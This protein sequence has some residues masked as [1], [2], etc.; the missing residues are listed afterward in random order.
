MVK[1]LSGLVA[2]IVIAVGGFFGFQFYTQHRI[3]SEV[4][5]ALEQVRA[6]G[7]KA[8][9]G[10]V[11]YDLLNR[12]VTIAEIAAQSAAQ[13]PVS[14]KIGN[15]TAS[16]VSQPDAAR[17]S[18]ETI[19]IADLDIG[20]AIGPQP[21]SNLS[22][23]LPRIT[24]K[25][26]SGPASLQRPPASSAL[27]DIYRSVLEQFAGVAA[28]SI[29]APSLTGTIN[30]GV[31]TPGGGEVAYTGLAMQDIKDGKVASAK[32]DGAVF[33]VNA[34]GAGGKPDKLT[35][36]LA[37]IAGYDIDSRAVAAMFD[38]Q[39]A[40]DD[41]YY[42]AYRQITTGPYVV[43]SGQGLNMRIDGIT[44][45]DL[46][47]RPSRMQ[48]PDLLAMIPAPGAAPPTPAQARAM[49]EKVAKLYEG[50]RIG[51]AEMR[52]FS[53]ETP[54][55]PVKLSAMRLDLDN[56]KVNEFAIEGVDGRAP[57]GPVKLG[58]FALKSLDV[59]NL[60]R[61]SAQFA[62][63]PPPPDKA[64]DMIP[65]IGGAELRG[66]VAPFKNTGKQVSI[67]QFSLDWGQFVGPIPTKVRMTT[68]M[69]TPLD[70]SDPILMAL[71]A[72]GLDKAVI[73]NDVGA[74]WTEATKTFALEPV[75][76][77]LG[78]L[79][80]ANAQLS[81][82]N[83]PRGVFTLNPVQAAAMAEQIE[84]GPIELVLRDT[85][86]IDI[87]VAQYARLQDVSREAARSAIVDMI[88]SA[89]EPAAAYPDVLAALDAVAR[90]IE[91]PRQTLNVKLTPRGKL[92]LQQLN[93]FMN[94]DPLLALS[95]FRIE[96]STGL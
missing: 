59:A 75:S 89:R 53:V 35:G 50:M 22:Y 10:K 92:P 48:V 31:A 58:R 61:L 68:R 14:V 57:E 13:P 85:G 79:L 12:T 76:L 77:E 42:R 16:G 26:Y 83:V 5:A 6:A 96:A 29:T 88:R 72:A 18:A 1:V 78:G 66:L 47:L 73:D 62:G 52:G 19:E 64:L 32:I 27:A 46:G 71:I 74:V 45:D 9:R 28:T 23:K 84:A 91:T 37:N 8:S 67:E 17:F 63:S 69:T 21:P 56:G 38:P 51:N 15:L 30:S 94:T 24:V 82:T 3:A 90:F 20:A 49:I 87:A 34:Q 81:L 7:G 25:E 2:A 41:Q 54:Q 40:S 36:N 11:S 93:Q 65:L 33:T 44:I 80:K 95:Q 39:K 43:S 55:G 60:L 86:A 70:A 4:D